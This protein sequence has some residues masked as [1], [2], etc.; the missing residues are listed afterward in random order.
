LNNF[1]GVCIYL[2]DDKKTLEEAVASFNRALELSGGKLVQVYYNL[3]YAL[4]KVGREADGKAALTK[5]LELNPG[6]PSA[7]EV[8]AIIANPKMVN[9]RFAPG[10]K[11][12]AFAG[13]DLSLEKYRGRI[14]LL[15]FWRHGADRAELKCRRPR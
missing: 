11:V 12:K 1:I 14:V 7:S 13:G 3:G 15:D 2:Q 6:A 5:Y 9:E 8:R 10:F 4:L